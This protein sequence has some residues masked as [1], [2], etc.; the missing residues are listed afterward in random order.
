MAYKRHAG[1]AA[2]RDGPEVIAEQVPEVVTEG[3]CVIGSSGSSGAVTA[4]VSGQEKEHRRLGR[5]AAPERKIVD[6]WVAYSPPN[7]PLSARSRQPMRPMTLK[8]APIGSRTSPNRPNGVSAA[9]RMIVPPSSETV[10]SALSA[11]STET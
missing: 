8:M 11:S 4:F 9:S 7:D 5:P 2:Q 1:E 10:A 6:R 3:P